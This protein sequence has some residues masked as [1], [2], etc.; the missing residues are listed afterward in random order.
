MNDPTRYRVTLICRCQ[1]DATEGYGATPE[2]AK[3]NA[4]RFFRKD[5]THRRQK[6]A[7]EYL[8]EAVVYD[9]RGSSRYV[10]VTA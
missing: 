1:N 6:P 5:R 10:E 2:E 9:A 3:A 4:Y 8:E 7:E